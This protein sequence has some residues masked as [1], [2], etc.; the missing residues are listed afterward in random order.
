[1]ELE[2]RPL[3]AND[4]DAVYAI[5]GEGIATGHATF[6]TAPTAWP[7]WDAGHLPHS[8]FVAFADGDI[9]GW[10]ALVPSSDRCAYRG[11]AEVSV[12]VA[13]RARGRGVGRALLARVIT[14]S[15]DAG[16]WTLTA[17]ILAENVASRRLHTAHGFR[18]L[19]VR[20]RIGHLAGEWRDV[21]LLERR[22]TVVG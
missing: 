3:T 12:Y 13:E 1:M 18:E 22:S 5:H 17:G 9:V 19:G 10:V 8:R 11:V 2:V 4:A 21:V 20:E 16:L 14:S 6:E 7:A 15:E